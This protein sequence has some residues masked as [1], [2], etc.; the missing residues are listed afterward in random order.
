MGSKMFMLPLV[1]AVKY[2]VAH[3]KY[4]G[5]EERSFTSESQHEMNSIVELHG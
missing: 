2:N 3:R 1:L 4:S 5:K